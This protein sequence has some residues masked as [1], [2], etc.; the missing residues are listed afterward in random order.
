MGRRHFNFSP[1]VRAFQENFSS[2]DAGSTAGGD[3]HPSKRTVQPPIHAH[4]AT[5]FDDPGVPDPPIRRMYP[6]REDASP[7]GGTKAEALRRRCSGPRVVQPVPT[8]KRRYAVGAHDPG[9][10]AFP[11]K[12]SEDL[13]SRRHVPGPNDHISDFKVV[14]DEVA[15]GGRRHSRA[16][17]AS[18]SSRATPSHQRRH[19][20][21]E[22][23]LVGATLHWTEDQ[24]ADSAGGRSSSIPPGGSSCGVAS[25]LRS[26]AV[27]PA[28]TSV[29]GRASDHVRARR[30]VE[31]EDTL[32]G[33]T[34]ATAETH[35]YE[36][37]PRPRPHSAPRC[38]RQCSHERDHLMGGVVSRRADVENQLRHMVGK[39]APEDSL[40]GSSFRHQLEPSPVPYPVHHPP[41][42]YP[43]GNPTPMREANLFDILRYGANQSWF[44]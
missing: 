27:T 4:E 44:E 16:A 33:G 36:R 37:P 15:G 41:V 17:S 20:G 31:V 40:I 24:P 22:D 7:A 6:N 19:L 39:P 25:V 28:K 34:L 8:S 32:F 11:D 9:Y 5:L 1:G 38:L 14:R 35:P 10:V 2:S 13:C 30:R 23:H 18:G 26:Q 42:P 3:W 12:A 43:A 21:R 29:G